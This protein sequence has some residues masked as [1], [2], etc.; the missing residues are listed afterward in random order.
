[1]VQPFGDVVLNE[2]KAV[3]E[4]EYDNNDE[5]YC[6]IDIKIRCCPWCGVSLVA[7]SCDG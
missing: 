1:M 3:L 7:G 6:T 5:I 2:Q 4:I